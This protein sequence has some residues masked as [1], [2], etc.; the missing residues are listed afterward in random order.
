V[1]AGRIFTFLTG[2]GA[3]AEKTFNDLFLDT[4]VNAEAA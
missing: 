3:M 2:G 1:F 4:E